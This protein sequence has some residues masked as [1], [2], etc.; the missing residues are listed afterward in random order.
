M[1]GLSAYR[2]HLIATLSR[3]VFVN[4]GWLFAGSFFISRYGGEFYAP[5]HL[6]ASVLTIACYLIFMGLS[7]RGSQISYLLAFAG[8]AALTIMQWYGLA[9]EVVAFGF[10]AGILLIDLV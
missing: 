10:C 4:L 9:G 8:A 3:G 6:T 5:L 7:I 2:Y 1:S